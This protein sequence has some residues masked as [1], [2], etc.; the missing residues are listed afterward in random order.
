MLLNNKKLVKILIQTKNI[1]QEKI[2]SQI[3]TTR[4]IKT[5][6]INPIRITITTRK[7]KIT[8]K[9]DKGRKKCI[10]VIYYIVKLS[11]EI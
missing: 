1:N 9:E 3:K 7:I 4:S 5:K 6:K 10:W 11:E 8:K 2:I